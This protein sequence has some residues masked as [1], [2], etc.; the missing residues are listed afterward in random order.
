MD[1]FEFLMVL[2]SIIIGLG[3]S[4]ILTNVAKHIRARKSV[5]G[6][7]VHSGVVVMLTLNIPVFKPTL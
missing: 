5:R 6:F 2:L 3:V 7:W 4:E 1:R